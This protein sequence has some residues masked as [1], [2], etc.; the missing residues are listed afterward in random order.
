MSCHR[1]RLALVAC[2]MFLSILSCNN[3]LGWTETGHKVIALIVWDQLTPAAR[4]KAIALLRQH[5][6]YEKD[7]LEGLPVGTDDATTA[8]HAFAA[9]STWPDVVRGQGHPMHFVANHP[10]WH[11]I[12]IPYA[13][14]AQPVPETQPTTTTTSSADKPGPHNV[15]EALTKN[16]AD[17]RAGDVSDAD[18]AIALCWVLHLGGDIHQPL[19]ATSLYSPQYPNGDQ[20]GNAQVVLR[21]PPYT[22]SQINLHL[23]W[24]QLPGVFKS[25]DL[26]GY[27]A[28]GLRNDPR[29]TREKLKDAIEIT[30]FVAWARESHALAVEHAYLNG[31]LKTVPAREVKANP[32]I[33]V[34]GVPPGYI[35]QA[36]EVAMRQCI[37]AGYR[38][39][40][41]LNG[42]LDPKNRPG[43]NSESDQ[44]STHRSSAEHPG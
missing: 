32:H 2:G 26:D 25:D 23:L 3:A 28:A 17:L 22:N 34:P 38:T 35:E 37:L 36:E 20:G 31:R 5:P 33:I 7:L 12:D 16:V 30:D 44:P 13:I 9:A 14:D 29:Y 1:I 39:A 4:A 41:L 19:H 18:K 43:P 42:I 10:D 11:Y 21:D 8:R 40:D 15:V 24:D 6:R 27:L